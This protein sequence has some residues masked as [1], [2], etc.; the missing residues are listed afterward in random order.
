LDSQKSLR[1]PADWNLDQWKQLTQRWPRQRAWTSCH[2]GYL[3]RKRALSLATKRFD[4]KGAQRLHVHTLAG[5]LGIHPSNFSVGYKDFLGVTQWLTRDQ[6][7]VRMAFRQMVFNV[8][9]HKP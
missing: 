1:A 4:R 5:M 7:A 6:R 9:A 2:S 8:L 3:K